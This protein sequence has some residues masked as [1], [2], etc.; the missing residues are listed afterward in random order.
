MLVL[1]PAPLRPVIAPVRARLTTAMLLQ[2][3]CALLV[4]ATYVA[5]I[6]GIRRSVQTGHTAWFPIAVAT[7]TLLSV[8]V[9]H[10]A[11]YALSF[12]ASRRVEQRLRDQIIAHM[13]RIP[14]GWFTDGAAITRLRKTVTTDVGAVS[15]LVAEGL[16][17]LARYTTVTVAAFGYLCTVSL[18]MA[19]IVAVPVIAASVGEWRRMGTASDAD[20]QYEE[21]AAELSART[22]E[23]TQGI[24]VAKVYGTT[25]S[26]DDRF[27]AAA[28]TYADS[29][30]RREEDQLRRGRR[31]AILASW[32]SVLGLVVITGTAFVAADLVTPVDV[33]A[34]ILLSWLVSRGVWAVPTALVT[35]RRAAAVLR[36]VD[37]LLT[38]PALPASARPAAAPVGP[39]TVQ[40]D[41]VEFGYTPG[42]PVLR[43]IDLTMRP[44]STTVLVG[45]SGSGKS[46]V[47]RLIPRFWNVERGSITLNDT[48][49]RDIAP[50]V[51]YR[52]VSFVF[53]DA[54]LL[55]M[56]VADN[57]RLARP[58]AGPEVVR[59]AAVAARIDDRIRRL[60]A[61]YDSIVGDDVTFSGGEAQRIC[62]ARAIVADTP[63][64]VLDEPTSAAD[65][66]SEAAVTHALSRLMSGRTV[67][68]VAHRLASIAA[69]DEIVVLEDGQVVENGH[70]DDLLAAEGRFAQM[71]HAD[72]MALR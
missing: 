54:E 60:P 67:L 65:P 35:W 7:I 10:A 43:G 57:I 21:A 29:Y 12:S 15:G 71:W 72:R 41:A 17:N 68:V 23:L 48:D 28:D 46:T 70:R 22:L 61:G 47:A 8:P 11:S 64:V 62:I 63:V 49:I 6:D 59:A 40:F 30:I 9:V 20:R 25:G 27:H 58:D 55:R 45:S 38:A 37:A 1:L 13:S 44:N 18:P 42:V 24:E 36:G 14:L 4:V 19:V 32:M 50:D 53:Q 3:G 34:F 33:A 16:P 52:L 31:T 2:V 66:E 5:I 26:T 39:V 56:S 51:L 69:S